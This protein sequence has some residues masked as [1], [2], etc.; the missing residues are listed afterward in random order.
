MRGW[1]LSWETRR[2]LRRVTGGCLLLAGLSLTLRYLPLWL[3][4]VAA[5]VTT[6]WMG[7]LLL[8]DQ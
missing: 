7:V 3:W 2:L 8:R 4:A 6:I 5:G 1:R